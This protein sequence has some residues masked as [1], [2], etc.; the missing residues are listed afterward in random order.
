M[1]WARFSLCVLAGAAALLAVGVPPAGAAHDN[2]VAAGRVEPGPLLTLTSQTSW[3]SPAAP[4]FS[5]ALGVASDAGPVDDLRVAVTIYGKIVTATDMA[6]STTAVPD[7]RVLTRFDT[8]IVPIAGSLGAQSCVTVLPDSSASPPA[9]APVNTVA[10]PVGAPTV[11]LG[12]VPGDGTCGGVYPVSVALERQGSTAPLARFTT[13]LTYQEP[14][15]SS[16]VGSGGALRVSLIVP[17][18]HSGSSP[19][20]AA[21][22]ARN[23]AL[24]GVVDAHRE[25]AVTLAADPGTVSALLERGGK[26]GQR[27]VAQLQSLTQDGIDQL[28]T[29]TYVPVDVAALAGAGL[30]GEINAQLLRGN[31]LLRAA[32]L[33]PTPGTWV[34]TS[35]DFTSADAANLALGLQTAGASRLILSDDQLTPAHSDSPNFAPLTYAQPFSLALGRSAHVTAAG[36]SAQVDSLFTAEPGDPVLTANQILATL[37]F[38]H[39]EDPYTPDPRGVVVTPPPSWQPSTSLM[40]TLL[41]GMAGNPVLSPVTLDDLFTQ[42]PK[43][44][45][46]EPAVR[47][48]R[49]GS[50]PR[51]A[52][53]PPAT[54]A[55]LASARMRLSSFSAAVI[56]HPAVLTELSDLLLA[57]EYQGFGPAERSVALNNYTRRF[58]AVLNLVSLAD[59]GPVTFTSRTAP[60][61]VSVLSSA[62]FPV[63]VVLTL[64]SD[65][66]TFPQGNSRSLTLDRPTTPV[67]VQAR[68][69]T[70]GDRLPVDATLTTPDGQ[71]VFAHTVLTV[72]ATSISLVGIALTAL[73]AVVLLV[74]WIRTW[75]RGPRRRPRGA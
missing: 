75:R 1:R 30:S 69:R 11:T 22:L 47:H 19:P 46:G 20:S 41:D 3:V 14:G 10:C 16:S 26:P 24:V 4:W 13:F 56:G 17:I 60:I 2:S 43:G 52:T 25:V 72:H 57:T 70:S 48:L 67:R 65:K 40:T 35:P 34:D 12:C 21:E 38:L 51:A 33:H 73:A 49:D 39:F 68:S 5:L 9:T 74:W 71:V 29:E 28:L 7:E 62:P 54:A 32:G 59:Q 64:S 6:A 61:P 36:A 58:T 53:I 63:R 18:S 42:V 31:T 55:H 50:T 15:L 44:G 23:E 66:F 45:N 8:P 27:S 37:E